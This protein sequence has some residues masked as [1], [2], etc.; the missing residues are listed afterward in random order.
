MANASGIFMSVL[1]TKNPGKILI[2]AI[3]I[4][5]LF[6]ITAPVSARY[7]SPEGS[8][9]GVD[10]GDTVFNGERGLNF[11]TFQPSTPLDPPLWLACDG[12]LLGALAMQKL[13]SNAVLSGSG[14][15]NV[16]S[17]YLDRPFKLYNGSW[18][19]SICLVSNPEGEIEVRT[20]TALGTDVDPAST[21]TKTPA[22]IPLNMNVQF[23]LDSTNMNNGNFIN[24]WYEYSLK[25][26]S[27]LTL[28]TVTNMDG[29]FISLSD[30]MGDPTA[31]NNTLAFSIA[32]QNLNPEEGT[33]VMEF[34]AYN[35]QNSFYS[36]DYEFDVVRYT[37][38]ASAEPS[39][40]KMGDSTTLTIIG[41]PYTYY[42]ISIEDTMDGRPE[43][44]PSGKYDIYVNEYEAV[45]H[46]G[47][48]G[49]VSV[50]LNIPEIEG[51]FSHTTRN[52]YP[53]VYETNNPD[54]FTTVQITVEPGTSSDI[55]LCDLPLSD[56]QYYCL[57]DTVPIKGKL[58]N[59]AG[60][61]MYIY[62]YITGN[63]LDSNGVKP[64]NPSVD[65]VDYDNSTFDSVKISKGD[66]EFYFEWDTSKTGLAS[67]TYTIFA[68]AEPI[69]YK[70]RPLAE[71][72]VKDY[73][74]VDLNE[75]SINVK[76]PEEAPGFFAQG[77]HIVSLWSARGS[78]NAS[79]NTGTIRYYIVGKNF[80][81]T[82]YREFP[83]LK[84][85]S[86]NTDAEQLSTL[87][88]KNDFPGY[89]GLDLS[90][91][92]SDNMGEGSFYIIYQHPM[93]NQIFDVLPEQGDNYKG[94]LTTVVSTTGQSV[95][96]S[97]LQSD[98]A[99]AALE[100]AFD[101]PY[102]DDTIVTQT[103]VIEYPRV[104]VDPVTDYEVGESI[105]ITG[106][107][108]LECALEYPYNQIDLSGDSLTLAV[109]DADLYYS[110]KTQSTNRIYSGST[111]PDSAAIGVDSREFSF[112]I[113]ADI[114][115][116]MEAG[117]YVGLIKC[118]DIKYEKAFLF[119]L[120]E[121]G[122][123]REQVSTTQSIGGGLSDKPETTTK[124]T[125]TTSRSTRSTTT[126]ATEKPEAT[127]KPAGFGPAFYTFFL[128]LGSYAVLYFKRR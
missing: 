31:D 96:I 17:E 87:A 75:A 69:G 126:L 26:A 42:T 46:P 3:L 21:D 106:T 93:N 125:A 119:T 64:S 70:S 58:G 6:S 113:P 91:S 23:K 94:T 124:V 36:T 103:F 4:L 60:S 57:G 11:S 67:G 43:L 98:S 90:R 13:D 55:E 92:F 71:E 105:P 53:K 45:V 114:S 9:A 97:A 120:H 61:D 127:A 51:D 12:G 49:T 7:S 77:D 8:N 16:E 74:A 10:P 63:N 37:L 72:E 20:G 116:R 39:P 35:G 123:D 56:D 40:V 28:S 52:F 99:L 24:P 66:T 84:V 111:Y 18:A 62:F 100:N 82:G 108:N 44:S 86:G 73:L 88:E 76:F 80:K 1:K 118:E 22:V 104:F 65:V 68:T 5:I 48:D 19:N 81:Y 85:D 109:Y 41:K 29:D 14:R 50:K 30:L 117:D 121:E 95:D 102:I 25:T 34:T 128:L 59:A 33:Y 83:I 89:S 79:S 78:P 47:W 2:M 115:A 32:D 110:G 54:T 27:G 15:L 112:R 122:Y 101:S 107:T 38:E